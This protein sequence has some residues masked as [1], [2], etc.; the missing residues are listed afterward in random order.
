MSKQKPAKPTV[1][2]SVKVKDLTAK[3]QV[4]GGRRPAPV[5]D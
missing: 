5:Q 3:S 1:K 2:T 4:K